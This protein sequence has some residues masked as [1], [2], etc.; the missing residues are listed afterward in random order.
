MGQDIKETYVCLD[1]NWS[2]A[3]IRCPKCSSTNTEGIL[4]VLKSLQSANNPPY[5]VKNNRLERLK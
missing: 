4:T 3:Y 5:L 2:D 1:C